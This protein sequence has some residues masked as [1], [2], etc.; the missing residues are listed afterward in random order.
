MSLIERTV[1]VQNIAWYSAFSV[2]SVTILYVVTHVD[3]N[4]KSISKMLC[5]NFIFWANLKIQKRCFSPIFIY[6]H[7]IHWLLHCRHESLNACVHEWLTRSLTWTAKHFHQIYQKS[8]I[9]NFI[10][11]PSQIHDHEVGEGHSKLSLC[12]IIHSFIKLTQFCKILNLCINTKSDDWLI[13][14]N[15]F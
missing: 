14:C 7:G 4:W 1:F 5:K 12:S 15:S 6:G 10:V 13:L 8:Q 3:W 2:F 11:D 9:F